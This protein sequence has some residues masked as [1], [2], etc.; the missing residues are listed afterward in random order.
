MG[1][2]ECHIFS[3]LL[4][5]G[6]EDGTK[7]LER[8]IDDLPSTVDAHHH[9]HRRWKK[10]L[11]GILERHEEQGSAT[12][13][14]IGHS[15]GALR[16]QQI[17]KKLNSEDISVA[18][19][20]GIDPTALF[21]WQPSMKLSKNINLVDEFHATRGFPYSARKNDPSG[22]G[23]GKFIVP[24]ELEGVHTTT[25]VPG[26]HIKCAASPITREKILEAVRDLV[27]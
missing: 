21:S 13:I 7:E 12:I 26:P 8:L 23:G 16:C 15:Y 17:A 9:H 14:L 1:R 18:Y 11:K 6:A 5:A 25:K 3:G 4:S 24:G 22:K 10:V 19:V 2:V 27:E 20:A